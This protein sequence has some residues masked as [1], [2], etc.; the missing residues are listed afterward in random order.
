MLKKGTEERIKEIIDVLG[1]LKADSTVP[2]NVK[3]K[4]DTIISALSDKVE[5]PIRVHRALNELEEIS[6][7]NNIQ[8]YTRA[9]IWNVVSMLEALG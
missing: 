6:D 2:K 3:A 5:A 8:A 7:D 9:Q 1:E 4:I